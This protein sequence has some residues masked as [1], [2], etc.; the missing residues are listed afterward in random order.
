ME[1]FGWIA[2]ILLCA[3]ALTF[4]I[5][6]LGPVIH[7]EI[8]FWKYRKQKSIEAK[9]DKFRFKKE[10]KD[11]KFKAKKLAYMKKNG[12]DASELE[13]GMQKPVLN[14]AEE[15]AISVEEDNLELSDDYISP[16]QETKL[17]EAPLIEERTEEISNELNGEP[18][19]F[20][21]AEENKTEEI[22]KP[23]TV[24]KVKRNL[25]K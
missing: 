18:P 19:L 1:I 4:I 15:E 9:E 24:I 16:E 3:V 7:S 20:E 25:H 8:S 14:E 11:L 23:T 21:I 17:T 2:L 6:T 13:L 12:L 10:M 5:I 22:K